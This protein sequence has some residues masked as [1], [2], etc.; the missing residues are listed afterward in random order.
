MKNINIDDI[1]D[2][3]KLDNVVTN[4]VKKG[5]KKEKIK[6]YKINITVIAIATVSALIILK[7]FCVK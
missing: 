4:A 5:Y 6:I 7:L 3:S 2:S 1:K